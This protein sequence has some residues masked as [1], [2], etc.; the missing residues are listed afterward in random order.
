MDA[1][2]EVVG[3]EQWF[4]KGY[5]PREN[6][7]TER[8]NGTILS[9][10]RKKTEVHCEWDNVLPHA[11]FAYNISPHE[12]TGESPFFLLHGY[13]AAFPSKEI[14]RRLLSPAHFVLEGYKYEK[15]AALKLARECV[16]ERVERY[17]EKMKRY[18]DKNKK[19]DKCVRVAVG[20]RVF[21]RLP[22]EKASAAFPKLTIDLSGPFRVLEF[23]ENSVLVHE[24][25]S[26]KEPIRIPF[27]EIV[28]V[29][30]WFD[31]TPIKVA[32]SRGRR[33][34]KGGG[35]V[36]KTAAGVNVVFRI[37]KSFD[38]GGFEDG[39]C[40]FG[41]FDEFENLDQNTKQTLKTYVENLTPPSFRIPKKRS[42][43][44]SAERN[45]TS[46][47]GPS[48]SHDFGKGDPSNFGRGAATF[49]VKPRAPTLA[50]KCYRCGIEGHLARECPSVDHAP[51]CFNCNQMGHLSRQ[52]KERK[53]STRGETE[54]A[55]EHP[56]SVGLEGMISRISR[57]VET[58]VASRLTDTI[59]SRLVGDSE[60]ERRRQRSRG[61]RSS[62]SSDEE[63]QKKKH[64]R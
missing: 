56:A 22:R 31:D 59:L 38:T 42:K 4:T 19:V 12:A 57:S 49:P 52:C 40:S 44:R 29:P 37:E 32:T 6:G 60:G 20:D 61:R 8:A 55:A 26:K 63:R 53:P 34:R 2:C 13:D 62:S 23:S 51:K 5:I 28:R 47:V 14:P 15:M 9:M 41:Q 30:E 7:L 3:V 16:T 46:P 21:V 48:S 33:G 1:I 64:R 43:E 24:I 18:Y 39:P 27:D 11:V 35:A 45:A 25:G 50:F 36:M 54:R 17:N 10:L 58:A